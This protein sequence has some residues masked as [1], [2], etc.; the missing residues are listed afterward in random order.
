MLL[1]PIASQLKKLLQDTAKILCNFYWYPIHCTYK[2]I[3][4]FLLPFSGKGVNK[5]KSLEKINVL[6]EQLCW[7]GIESEKSV[8]NLST[9]KAIRNKWK[10]KKK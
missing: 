6:E 4:F 3:V 7:K 1:F 10:L 9:T 2:N 8:R 5:K